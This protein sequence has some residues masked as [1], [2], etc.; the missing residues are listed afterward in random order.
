MGF[1]IPIL[2]GNKIRNW[3]Q[4]TLLMI[5]I[6]FF[7]E[8]LQFVFNVGVADVDDIVL[9]TLGALI[10]YGLMQTKLIQN[11]LKKIEVV[12]CC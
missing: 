8:L 7:V 10:V 1:F 6:V 9:N 12:K 3:L 4:F 11:I 5:I 2:M